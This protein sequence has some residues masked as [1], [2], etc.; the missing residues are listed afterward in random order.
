MSG[1]NL[2]FVC[3][4]LTHKLAITLSNTTSQACWGRKS[5]LQFVL[6]YFCHPLSIMLNISC[7]FHLKAHIRSQRLAG[8]NSKIKSSHVPGGECNTSNCMSG[9]FCSCDF[10]L[11][12][13]RGKKE[14]ILQFF[15]LDSRAA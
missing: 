11:L 13:T 12:E 10:A 1:Q 8:S 4:R 6:S 14:N 7:C 5:T 9:C 15:S 3:D 2:L